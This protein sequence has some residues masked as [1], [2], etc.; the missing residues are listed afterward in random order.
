MKRYS[1]QERDAYGSK[2]MTSS[3]LFF[4]P[5]N[6]LHPLKHLQILLNQLTKY[7]QSINKSWLSSKMIFL[8]RKRSIQG[9]PEKGKNIDFVWQLIF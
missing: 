9:L 2:P 4:D 1:Y 6:H 5:L 8:P 7:T 3:L